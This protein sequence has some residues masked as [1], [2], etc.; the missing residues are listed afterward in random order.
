V[1]ETFG[2]DKTW[3]D[4]AHHRTGGSTPMSQNQWE[5]LGYVPRAPQVGGTLAS[6]GRFPGIQ[7]QVAG[8][9]A[10]P[11]P[12]PNPGMPR[13]GFMPQPGSTDPRMAVPGMNGSTQAPIASSVG[14]MASSYRRI[15]APDGRTMN[16][17]ESKMQEAL[18]RGG[19]LA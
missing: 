17:P 9:S 15:I 6:I 8:A 10:M 11:G 14:Q 1:K 7:S 5:Q 3:K 4:L 16:V 18:Q 12:M 2:A 13:Q 19:R